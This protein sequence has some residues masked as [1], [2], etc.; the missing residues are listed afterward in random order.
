MGVELLAVSSDTP[1]NLKTTQAKTGAD[2]TFLSDPQGDIFSALGIL[3]QGGNPIDGGD[4]A[5]PTK[6]LVGG[7]GHLI[8]AYQEDNYR[9]RLKPDA[10]LE[11]VRESLGR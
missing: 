1:E 5:R 7:D 10:V 4:I 9:V 6:A 11:R 8:W 2:W 3:H